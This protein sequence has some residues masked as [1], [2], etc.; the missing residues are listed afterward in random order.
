LSSRWFT[1]FTAGLYRKRALYRD[2]D[3]VPESKAALDFY[4][5]RVFL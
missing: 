4:V 1:G 2:Y 5:K 3:T